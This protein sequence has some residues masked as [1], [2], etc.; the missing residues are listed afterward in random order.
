MIA[1]ATIACGVVTTSFAAWSL[2]TG[3][4]GWLGLAGTGGVVTIS[5]VA[6]FAAFRFIGAVPE[7]RS[8]TPNACSEF[9]SPSLCWARASVACS[10]PASHSQSQRPPFSRCRH[11]N[12]VQRETAGDFILSPK[13]LIFGGVK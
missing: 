4:V 2:P 1:G 6:S 9:F 5:L 12:S 11:C 13:R 10:G 3:T 7:R 8:A